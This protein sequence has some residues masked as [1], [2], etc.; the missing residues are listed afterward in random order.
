MSGVEAREAVNSRFL[1]GWRL[2][3]EEMIRSD[4]GL[5]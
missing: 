5:D 2:D 4:P 3:L 1:A